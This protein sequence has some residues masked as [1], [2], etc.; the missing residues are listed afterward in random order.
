MNNAPHATEGDAAHSRGG[1]SP[2]NNTRPHTTARMLG[3]SLLAV[4]VVAALAVIAHRT[5]LPV[6]A[7]AAAFVSVLGALL[8]SRP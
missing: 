5:G 7:V 8:A 1:L 2:M 4:A 6:D 3:A